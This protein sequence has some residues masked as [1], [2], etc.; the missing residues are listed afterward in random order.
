[1]LQSYFPSTQAKSVFHIDY[2]KLKNLGFQAIIFDIDQTLVPH[3]DPVTPELEDLFQQIHQLGFKTF[4]LS[5]ND[6]TRI[7]PFAQ[8]LATDYLPMAN[9]P[10][11]KAYLK[12]LDLL[13]VS[14][15]QAVFIGDQLFTDILGANRAGL[16]SILVDY[17]TR[18]G[19][20]RRSKKRLVE[21]ILLKFYPLRKKS[22]HELGHIERKA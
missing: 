21:Q 1:M 22:Q 20:S 17:L 6:A 10:Q 16:A 8:A 18:P 11:A 12:A 7:A 19:E 9:K 5:N 3:G 15:D 13:Q 14:A 2:Q 4:L